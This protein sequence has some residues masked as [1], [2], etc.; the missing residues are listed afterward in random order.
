MGAVNGSFA[1]SARGG[2]GERWVV[3]GAAQATFNIRNHMHC[4]HGP[5][6]LVRVVGSAN[7]Y[8]NSIVPIRMKQNQ[9]DHKVKVISGIIIHIIA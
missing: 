2:F 6:W 8:A 3:A 7:Y 5:K 9:S 4:I 1:S